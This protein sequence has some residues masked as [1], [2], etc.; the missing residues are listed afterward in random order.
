ME[1]TIYLYFNGTCLEAMTFYA[2]TLGGE[3]TGV[4]KN[5]DAPDPASRMPGGDDM[6][7]HMSMA[8]GQAVVMA[9]LDNLGKGASGQAVQNMTLMLNLG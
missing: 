6:I 3:I 1:P 7:M 2:E 4:F 8:L 9:L 5:S